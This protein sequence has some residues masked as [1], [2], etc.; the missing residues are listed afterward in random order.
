[1]HGI[2]FENETS[3]ITEKQTINL[4][5]NGENTNIY[6]ENKSNQDTTLISFEENEKIQE[7]DC[8]K[9]IVVKYEDSTNKIETTISQKNT[10]VNE[11]EN[12]VDLNDE[13]SIIINDLNEQQL[14][15]VLNRV[16]SRVSEKINKLLEESIKIDDLTKMLKN[17][18]LLEENSIQVNGITETEKDRFNSQ[19]E[20]LKAEGLQKDEAIKIIDSAKNNLIGIDVT[21]N[22]TLKLELDRNN[23]DEKISETVSDYIEKMQNKKYNIS[24]EY[25]EETGLA[26]YIVL[27]IVEQ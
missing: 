17:I 20:L 1:M 9:T 5:K 25:D 3:D 7:N 2:S 22:T 26:K 24:I 14:Q 21:S 19:F 13:N 16:T 6:Y 18:G 4:L 27:N 23:Y 10:I 11:F 12:K 15:V 8:N